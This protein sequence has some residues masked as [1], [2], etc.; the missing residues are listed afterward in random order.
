M[1]QA[2]LTERGELFWVL[3]EELQE[4]E[5]VTESTMMG[6]PCLRVNKDFFTSLERHTNNLIVKL[7]AGRVAG[8]VADGTGMAFAPAGRTFKEWV[9]LPAADEELWRAL[10]TEAKAFV[11]G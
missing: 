8:L 11:D 1:S 10:M 2:D 7:P 5:A 4:D 3:A 6:F 9:Q